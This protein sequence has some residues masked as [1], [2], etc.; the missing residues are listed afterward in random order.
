MGNW[1]ESLPGLETASANEEQRWRVLGTE[2][3]LVW[4]GEERVVENEVKEQGLPVSHSGEERGDRYY[5][6]CSGCHGRLS[7][8]RLKGRGLGCALMYIMISRSCHPTCLKRSS[9][10]QTQLTKTD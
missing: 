7:G 9:L 10:T 3:G 6:N 1:G 5:S 8:V 4:L 2:K